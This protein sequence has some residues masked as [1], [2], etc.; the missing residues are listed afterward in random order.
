MKEGIDGAESPAEGRSEIGEFV[1]EL[2]DLISGARE[3][4]KEDLSVLRERVQGNAQKANDFAH[5]N[6]W[7]VA[8]IAAVV[9]LALGALLSRR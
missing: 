4:G 2:L 8:A 6:P 3:R 1:D 9:G 5:A 7:Q